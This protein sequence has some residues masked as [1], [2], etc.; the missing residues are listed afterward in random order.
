M[1]W[2][3]LIIAA[4]ALWGWN[5]VNVKVIEEPLQLAY[6]WTDVKGLN[7]CII[8]ID[9]STATER[10]AIHEAGHCIGY[11]LWGTPAG[12]PGDPHHSHNPESVMY[13]GGTSKTIL[14]EDFAFARN[15]WIKWLSNSRNFSTVT[16]PYISK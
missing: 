10:T 16:V 14:P 3:A 2:I 8:H 1:S 9:P 11:L 4:L 15:T 7:G 13:S 6:A 12:A 5:G